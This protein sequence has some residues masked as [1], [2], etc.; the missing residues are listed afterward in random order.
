MRPTTVT[1]REEN[2]RKLKT[3]QNRWLIYYKEV[4]L[5]GTISVVFKSGYSCIFQ[6]LLSLEGR[7]LTDALQVPEAQ[8]N[9]S[10]TE[11]SQ[12]FC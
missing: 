10:H 12:G 5:K 3:G 6:S 7:H 1:K 4:L 11:L 2:K 8:A 9:H